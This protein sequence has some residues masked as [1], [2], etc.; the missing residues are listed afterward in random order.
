LINRDLLR[1]T[2]HFNELERGL[3]GI[4]RALLTVRLRQ[5]QRAGLL[6]R[7]LS[8]P[9]RQTTPYRLTQAGRNLFGVIGALR[10][11]G[12]RGRSATRH[13]TSSTRSC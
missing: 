1:G 2:G 13:Q 6:E 10:A 12:R 7:Q 5:L 8:S 4:L 3:P 11:W 9:G